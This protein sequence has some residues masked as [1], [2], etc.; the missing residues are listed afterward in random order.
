MALIGLSDKR[1]VVGRAGHSAKTK[2]HRGREIDVLIFPF[3]G[4]AAGYSARR[5]GHGGKMWSLLFPFRRLFLFP[6]K[7]SPRSPHHHH[8]HHHHHQPRGFR[9][10]RAGRWWQRGGVC[11]KEGG[12]IA[13]SFT[14]YPDEENGR[15]NCKRGRA[16][17]GGREGGR[18]ASCSLLFQF[19]GVI[20][21]HSDLILTG[22]SSD[23]GPENDSGYPVMNIQKGNL[24]NWSLEGMFVSERDF[25]HRRRRSK[26]LTE[27]FGMFWP[28]YESSVCH[29]ILLQWLAVD[30]IRSMIPKNQMESKFWNNY[31]SHFWS[32]MKKRENSKNLI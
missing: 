3:E 22:D 24:T 30:S 14:I 17:W 20:S 11:V 23:P 19:K 29:V 25:T 10:S 9:G 7:G 5:R 27:V 16:R 13:T 15:G 8:R 12:I 21:A 2:A 1:C 32:E 28:G 4:Q 18:V 26:V 31:L 6:E